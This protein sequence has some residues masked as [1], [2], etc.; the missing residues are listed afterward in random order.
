MSNPIIFDTGALIGLFNKSEAPL[1]MQIETYIEKKPHS[2]RLV[3]EPNLVELFYKLVKKG[4]LLTPRDVKTNLE[5]FAIEI[6]PVPHDESEKI[7]E[8]FMTIN[9]KAVFDYADFYMCSAAA[10]RTPTSEILTVDR[11]DLPLALTTALEFFA[12]HGNTSVQLIPF[13]N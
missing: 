7:R 4:R 1:G 6:Y 3:Y 2:P 10:L 9:H 5:H 11:Q 8:S 12:R 13:E